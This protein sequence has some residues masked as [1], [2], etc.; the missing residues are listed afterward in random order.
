MD[1]RLKASYDWVKQTVQSVDEEHAPSINTLARGVLDAGL[2]SL[3]KPQVALAR[4]EALREKEERRKQ[5][6]IQQLS[7]AAGAGAAFVRK[8]SKTW[9]EVSPPPPPPPA[10]AE[11]AV[12]VV[13]MK[14]P[15]ALVIVPPPPPKPQSTPMVDPE[16][17]EIDNF[18]MT[19]IAEHRK[20]NAHEVNRAYKAA[21][22][23][24]GI[25]IPRMSESLKVARAVL[26]VDNEP[27]ET[28]KPMRIT[29]HTEDEAPETE[30][31]AEIEEALL[32]FLSKLKKKYH[33]QTLEINV[34]ADGD[35]E[36]SAERQVVSHAKGKAKL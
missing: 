14:A 31:E 34:T 25:W 1:A 21:H 10:P 27:T 3:T 6:L 29:E 32:P 17:L 30:W 22:D 20:A 33:L 4:R 12:V 28:E 7:C 36:W 5:P 24:R 18:V 8:H 26:G 2:P 15:P 23:G 9:F 11:E 13:E 16:Q 35:L 19:Y